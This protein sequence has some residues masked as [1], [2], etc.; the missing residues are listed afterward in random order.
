MSLCLTQRKVMAFTSTGWCKEKDRKE[1]NNENFDK[2][3]DKNLNGK[4][5]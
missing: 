3:G 2:M 5:L 1:H 4:E